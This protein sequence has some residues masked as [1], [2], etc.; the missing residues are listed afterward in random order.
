MKKHIL[1]LSL[2][3]LALVAVGTFAGCKKGE[4]DPGISLKSRKSRLTGEWK[5]T[6]GEA[7]STSGGNTT[8]V[9]FT[10]TSATQVSGGTTTNFT[11]SMEY[12]FEKDGTYTLNE[13]A[14]YPGGSP[15]TT[16]EVG[17]WAFIGGNKS[18]DYKN[19][20][21]L[22]LSSTSRTY[23]GTGTCNCTFTDSNPDA[24][25]IWEIDQ[26]KG[27]EMV[28]KYKNTYT[29]PSGTDV[30]ETSLTLTAK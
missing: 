25:D 18:A 14:T 29:S 5:L 17:R 24:G 15:E 13:V 2:L 6:K 30:N 7:K 16:K 3:S 12:K 21:A 19:K 27:K 10:E 4:N 23:S 1:K 9:T 11:Y 20:E 22:L 26:L 28:I 8:T